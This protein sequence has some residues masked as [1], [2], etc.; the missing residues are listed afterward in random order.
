M[1]AH[2]W[3]WPGEEEVRQAGEEVGHRSWAGPTRRRR[4]PE[5]VFVLLLLEQGRRPW[6]D[7]AGTGRK[8]G[9]EKTRARREQADPA[10]NRWI[11]PSAAAGGVLGDP[12]LHGGGCPA[13][14]RDG[15]RENTGRKGRRPG[16]EGLA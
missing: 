10:G 13:K 15:M 7:G 1:W 3:A 6:Q 2:P 4:Q 8:G 14:D 5:R 11:R 16:G 9:E 12:S